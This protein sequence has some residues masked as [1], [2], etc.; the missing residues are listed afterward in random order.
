MSRI[1][2]ALE[3]AK[4]MRGGS[5]PFVLLDDGDKDTDEASLQLTQTRVIQYAP[6][7]A[8]KHNIVTLDLHNHELID[9]YKLLKTQ[10]LTKTQTHGDRTLLIT[11]CLDGEG[12][13]FNAL[14]LAVTFAKEIDQTVLLVDV[15]LKNPAIVRAFG[16][17]AEQGLTDYLVHDKPIPELLIRPG[18]EKLA[19]LPAG[20]FMPNST[21]LLGSVKMQLLISE[22]KNRY[23]DRYIFFDAPSILTCVDTLVLSKY[24]DKILLVVESGKVSPQKVIEGV[25]LI[26]EHK[27]LGT[28]LNKGKPV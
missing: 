16:I 14:N 2:D 10:I 5:A 26:G 15:N 3:K 18:I 22:M 23:K 25:N 4:Q 20:N 13:T 19:I 8:K 6:E 24:V 11:S 27:I 21:E 28:I 7:E 12:K 17:T 9:R 1:K